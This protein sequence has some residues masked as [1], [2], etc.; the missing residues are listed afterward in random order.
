VTRG[1]AGLLLVAAMAGGASAAPP[2][3]RYRISLPA[4][5]ATDEG[6][7]AAVSLTIVPD[8]SYSISRSGPLRLSLAVQPEAGLEL[9]RT[10]YQR[11]HAA[12]PQADAPRFDLALRGVKA[13]R[14]QLEV[15]LSFWLCRGQV[16]R[17]IRATRTVAVEV[18]APARAPAALTA[19]PRG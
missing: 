6:Q 17:P 19:R 2:P 14:Y 3:P 1:G 15:D 9:P 12:D 13:G 18:R 7:G 4:Q 5:L 11:S 8:A 16:C 10:R